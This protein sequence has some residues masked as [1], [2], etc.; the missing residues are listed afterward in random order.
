MNTEMRNILIALNVKYQGNWMDI[1][2]AIS[3]KER[4]LKEDI[5][6]Y[7]SQVKNNCLTL[8]DDDFPDCLKKTFQPPF[9]IYYKGNPDILRSRD[10][11]L[12]VV[13]TRHPTEDG[14][15]SVKLILND[16][17]K[18]KKDISIVSGMAKGIDSL[19]QRV[20]MENKCRVISVLGSGINICYPEEN[21]DIYEYC[22]KDEG[23]VISE[24]P[25]DC[26][27]KS[28]NFPMRNRLIA[29]IS[30]TVMIGEG[31]EQS[32]TKITVNYALEGGK[33]IICIPTRV[34][35]EMDLCNNLIRDGAYICASYL[36]IL[37]SFNHY[38][39]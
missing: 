17:L 15:K 13:G 30:D 25:N 27:P 23:L 3:R 37:D 34:F 8:I 26:P 1:R 35:S 31:K 38:V 20:F 29:C 21:K 11:R 7:V 28:E 18:A 5:N 32:G 4:I 10:K 14:K 33:T 36:D 39:S 24:Y 22:Q 2:N 16:L 19:A 12:A 6:K 9:V